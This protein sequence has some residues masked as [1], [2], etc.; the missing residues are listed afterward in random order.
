MPRRRVPADAD[1]EAVAQD[2]PVEADPPAGQDEA[3]PGGPEGTSAPDGETT[4]TLRDDPPTGTGETAAEAPARPRRRLFA[5]R[6]PEAQDEPPAAL[7]E[8]DPPGGD[9]PEAR[10]DRDAGLDGGVNSLRRRRKRLLRDRE[11]AVYHLGG[12][13]YE[14]HRRDMLDPPV[15]RLRADAIGLVDETVHAIDVRLEEL[16]AEREERR[17][18]GGGT[19][20]PA[21]AGN[22][23]ACRAPFYL[24]ARFC[25]QCGSRLAPGDD[26]EQVT[27]M[28]AGRPA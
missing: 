11:V 26:D 13:A 22:C 8:D 4:G 21:T 25:W 7:A 14:L 6:S 12:L 23:L 10:E 9:D 19:E 15:L 17:A 1:A 28:I 3:A 20:A 24:D 2:G 5:R 16:A 18:R 27:Q